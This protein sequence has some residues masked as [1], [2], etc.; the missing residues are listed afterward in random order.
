MEENLNNVPS[1]SEFIKKN[2]LNKTW[3]LVAGLVALTG[4]LLI[5]SLASKKISPFETP[6]KQ[7]TDIAHTSLSISDQPRSASTAGTYETDVNIDSQDNL[8]TGVQ[9]EISYDPKVLTNVE[10]KAGDFIPNSIVTQKK[11]DSA[12]GTISYWLWISQ[13]NS[14][15]KGKGTVAVISFSKTGSNET[16]INFLPDTVVGDQRYGQSVLRES[17]SAVIGNLPASQ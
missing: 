17:T 6:S 2:K 14:G 8:I 12:K 11:V 7:A 9:L 3:L 15:A 10:I 13:G 4:V 16:S 5:V 1:P